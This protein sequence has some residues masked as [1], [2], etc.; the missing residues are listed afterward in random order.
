MHTYKL[1]PAPKRA[2]LSSVLICLQFNITQAEPLRLDEAIQR[3]QANNPELLSRMHLTE[4]AAARAHIAGSLPDPKAQFT[5][6][7]ESV[8]TRTGPQEAIYSISQTIPWWTKLRR[9]EAIAHIDAEALAQLEQVQQQHLAEAVTQTYTEAAY[10]Q[11][12]VRTFEAKIE[13]IDNARSMVEEQVRGGAPLNALLRL[14]VER[15]STQDELDQ[16]KQAHFTLRTQLAALLGMEERMLGELGEMPLPSNQPLAPDALLES[17]LRHNP[18]LQVL[19]SRLKSA[20]SQVKLSQLDRYP[21]FTFGINY[22]QVGD[23]GSTVHNAGQDPW[24]VS[25]AIN[26]PIWEGK[27]RAAI[28]SAQ[29]SERAAEQMYLNRRLQLKAELSAT[30]AAR[31]DSLRRMN[32]YKDS[33]IPLAMQA[34]ENTQAAYENAR[35]S[36]L[37]VIDSERALLDLKLNYSKALAQSLQANARL[38]RLTGSP[39]VQ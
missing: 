28:L 27:N 4:S 23:N 5:Y 32:R 37:E 15:E 29:A 31:A 7:G 35:V 13:W 2:L 11:Q 22:I 39:L 36:V 6:F 8:E 33:L 17:L 30:L 34:L 25:I 18:E 14:E 16:S 26:L 9:R 20:D 24:N 19:R 10:L 1:F 38:Q 3:A 12:A 21:D